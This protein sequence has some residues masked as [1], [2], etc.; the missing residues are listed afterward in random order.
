MAAVGGEPLDQPGIGSLDG[1]VPIHGLALPVVVI[2][3]PEIARHGRQVIVLIGMCRV[4]VAPGIIVAYR[5]FQVA[6]ILDII[7][8]FTPPSRGI[9]AS[10]RWRLG[11]LPS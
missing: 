10:G 11:A 7:S 2:G 8:I 4:I 9:R 6:M 5:F 3:R 1:R